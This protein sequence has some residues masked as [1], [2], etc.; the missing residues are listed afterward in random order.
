V[1]GI[2]D[3]GEPRILRGAAKTTV[4]SDGRPHR[5]PLVTFETEATSELVMM[6][7]LLPL[8]IRKSTQTN[9]GSQPILAGPVDLIEESGLVGRTQVLFVAPGERFE[10]GWG[11]DAGIRAQRHVEEV[12][13]PVSLLNSWLS[14]SYRVDVSISSLDG[15]PRTIA[16]TEAIPVSEIEKVQV[17]L[18]AGTTTDGAWPDDDGF[19]RWNVRL[20]AHGRAHLKLRYVLKRHK[21]V[22]VV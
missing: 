7:A 17:A 10:L 11:P 12:D 19:V 6:P 9:A 3:G 4:V 14:R 18:D 1:P 2:D 16:V 20:G 13:E 15:A 22:G 5:I 8:A 21:D